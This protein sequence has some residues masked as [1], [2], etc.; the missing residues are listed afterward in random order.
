[1]AALALG[2]LAACGAAD[3]RPVAALATV[4][5]DRVRLPFGSPLETRFVFERS[6]E[7]VVLEGPYRVFVHYTDLD[8]V[9]LWSDD[10]DPPTPVDAWRPGEPVSWTRSFFLPQV[11][12]VGPV[13]VRAGLFN[14]ETGA[15]LRLGGDPV[16]E[17]AYRLATFD[18]TAQ[19]HP[20][21][22]ADG[23][24]GA[25][26]GGDARSEQWRWSNGAGTLAFVNPGADVTLHL[27]L[28]RPAS[29]PEPQLVQVRLGETV[30]DEFVLPTGERL[31]REVAVP[32]AALGDAL[33]QTLV[34][35]ARP[36][37]VPAGMGLGDDTREL[38]VRVFHA[39]LL[40]DQ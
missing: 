35:T 22:F 3:E 29:L 4:T 37:F 8:G 20:L 13:E 11:P 30:L 10:H 25:E 32:A 39:V 5:L 21:D 23:W 34:I 12:H 31:Q 26:A 24:H 2:V 1:V 36:T 38:G 9:L 28:D 18:V 40:P 15:R 33:A 6:D 27:D 7:P 17:D 19:T 14:L 16:G